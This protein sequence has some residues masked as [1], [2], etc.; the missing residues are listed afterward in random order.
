MKASVL[1]ILL[2]SI[3]YTGCDIF[4]A[5]DPERPNQSATTSVSASDPQL[6]LSNFTTALEE[7]NLDNY[8]VCFS[9][10]LL[11]GRNFTF[12]PSSE[13]SLLYPA[14]SSGWD[15]KSEKQYFT[16]MKAK[17]SS[18][19]KSA[20]TFSNTFLSLMGDSAVY[21]ATYFLNVPH[22]DN[23]SKNYEGDIKLKIFRDSR[24]VWSIYYWQD[25]KTSS[26]PSWSELKGRM[27]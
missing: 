20:L 24:L 7:S 13:A 12:A 9:D 19:S 23:F 15:I 8:L 3:C 16:N 10:S 17:I 11:S 1:V 27:Y 25:L 4:S 21:T 5:R 14:L 18:N 26:N 22:T 6:L 2:F